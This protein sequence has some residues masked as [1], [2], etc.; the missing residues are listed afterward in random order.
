MGIVCK[1]FPFWGWVAGSGGAEVVW[2]AG[3]EG[4]REDAFG[5]MELAQVKWW[6][7][8]ERLEDWL[9]RQQEADVV[10]FDNIRPGAS[11]AVWKLPGVELVIWF[12]SYSR[13]NVPLGW[14]RTSHLIRHSEL[15]GVT[16]GEFVVHL[17]TRS[18]APL[19]KL[20]QEVGVRMY[21]ASIIDK[22]ANGVP[23]SPPTNAED[24]LVD[25]RQLG[26]RYVVPSVFSRTGFV[27]RKLSSKEVNLVWDLPATIT[28]SCPPRLVERLV[29]EVRL[30]F[31]IRVHAL[32]VLTDFSDALA[33][34]EPARSVIK[35][36]AGDSQPGLKSKHEENAGRDAKA[37]KADDA[38]VPRWLWNE[39]LHLL[40]KGASEEEVKRI[41]Q[42]LER[43]RGRLH[44]RWVRNLSRSFW[45]WVCVER[46]AGRFVPRQA[47]SAGL[48]AIGHALKS[49]WWEWKGGSA[50]FFW[51][52]PAAFQKTIRDGLP[53]RFI[54]KPPANKKPQRVPK[55]AEELALV[56]AK[57]NKLRARKY[58]AVGEVRSLIN[59]FPVSKGESDIRLV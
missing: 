28:K 14:I 22:T 3:V 45:R 40:D 13:G 41:D 21:L 27:R 49:D 37:T 6:D 42:V 31:K 2:I 15:G 10:C 8:A 34:G 39:R 47:I 5:G 4:G 7:R 30:P 46:T 56:V 48:A 55:D 38:E 36:Q 54:D 9:A 33:T 24:V 26:D 19:A 1:T 58:I 50:P 52:W 57:V 25:L 20:P 29:E 17:A 18:D 43:F 44:A 12:G 32:S 35:E 23:C 51:R 59:M 53:P 11:H 16:N